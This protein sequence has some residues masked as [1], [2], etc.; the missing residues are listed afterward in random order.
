MLSKSSSVY[1][2]L[3]FAQDKC[4]DEHDDPDQDEGANQGPRDVGPL[5]DPDSYWAGS[6][7][8]Q[9]VMRSFRKDSL[10]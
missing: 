9:V 4:L 6:E 1:S 8:S 7:E 3:L 5:D 2:Q 10:F